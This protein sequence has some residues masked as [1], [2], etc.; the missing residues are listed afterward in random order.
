M[1]TNNYDNEV[2]LTFVQWYSSLPQTMFSLLAAISGGTD[3]ITI[4]EPVRTIGISYQIIFT[5]YVFFIV[6]GV[7]NVLTGVFLESAQDVHDRDLTVQAE[8]AR[9]DLFVQEMLDLFTE[10]VPDH[11]GRIT[12][13]QFQGYIH[14]EHVE[15]YMSSHMLETTHA[16][17][18]FR[19]LDMDGNGVIGVDEFVI[20]MLRLKGG[21]KTYDAR[22]LLHEV[23]ALRTSVNVVQQTVSA[24]SSSA[25]HHC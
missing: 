17:L 11:D 8:I 18:L 22:L 2:R 4:M 10:F 9:L 19:M 14:Q 5:F 3:W 21:A 15:A 24:L 23:S 7:L 20:G 12:W 13:E 1:R 6:V 25:M 16:R